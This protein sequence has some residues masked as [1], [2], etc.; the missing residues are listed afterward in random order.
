MATQEIVLKPGSG[1]TAG[2]LFVPMTSIDVANSS[3]DLEID[4]EPQAG[5]SVRVYVDQVSTI[6]SGSKT[7]RAETFDGTMPS[8]DH[9]APSKRLSLYNSLFIKA[10]PTRKNAH[11]RIIEERLAA[12][13][14]EA[15]EEGGAFDEVSASY[16]TA[17]CDDLAADAKPAVFLLEPGTLR[18]VWQDR[19]SGRQI[20]LQFLADGLIQYVLL[21]QGRHA[22]LKTLGVERASIVKQIVDLVGLRTLWFP[23]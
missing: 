16:L 15:A 14:E 12:L 22:M 10:Q 9:L 6:R 21:R 19:S 8:L 4:Y 3:Y 7:Q 5:Q 13:R 20:G 1:Q 17:F 18:A 11:R 2:A 23:A